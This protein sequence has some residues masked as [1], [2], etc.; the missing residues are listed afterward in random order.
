M[1]WNNFCLQL[2]E[3]TIIPIVQEFYLPL[4]EREATRPFYEL[5]SFVKVKG[6]NVLVTER[7]IYKFYDALY[8]YYDY[9]YK[10]DLNEFRNV[11]MK[12]ILKFLTEGKE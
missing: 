3:P 8:Y 10:T 12:E 11:D 2:E 5:E 4:K 6:F 7:C 1:E 9:V